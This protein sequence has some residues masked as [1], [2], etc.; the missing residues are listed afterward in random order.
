MEEILSKLT[1]VQPPLVL[2]FIY[3]IFNNSMQLYET[4][5]KFDEYLELTKLH[6]KYYNKKTN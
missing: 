5:L 6:I 1:N 2:R 3:Q 4:P